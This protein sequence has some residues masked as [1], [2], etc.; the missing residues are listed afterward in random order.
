M[1]T[2]YSSVF[3]DAAVLRYPIVF[4]AYDLKEYQQNLRGFYLDY[5]KDLP[6]PIVQEEADLWATVNEALE[7]GIDQDQRNRF[8]ERFAPKDDGHAAERVV[9]ELY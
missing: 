7:H 4:F 2:D 9:D 3:F 5:M 6:G 8:I 1:I